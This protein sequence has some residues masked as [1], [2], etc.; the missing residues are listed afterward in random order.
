MFTNINRLVLEEKETFISLLDT[1]YKTNSKIFDSR[2]LDH[3]VYYLVTLEKWIEV[4]T[5]MKKK[6]SS[7]LKYLNI[8]VNEVLDLYGKCKDLMNIMTSSKIIIEDLE[9]DM[10]IKE[11]LPALLDLYIKFTLSL[12]D[13]Q[14]KCL[15]RFSHNTKQTPRLYIPF[16]YTLNKLIRGCVVLQDE[17]NLNSGEVYVQKGHIKD[18]IY[19][20][21]EGVNFGNIEIIAYTYRKVLHNIRLQQGNNLIEVQAPYLPESWCYMK[22]REEQVQYTQRLKDVAFAYSNYCFVGYN[23]IQ[24]EEGKN[25][26]YINFPMEGVYN[27]S[28]LISIALV[29]QHELMLVY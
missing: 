1:I 24:N 22:G 20:Y 6:S 28:S 3:Q 4:L 14:V 23:T 26:F 27:K 21:R 18:N 17:Q 25:K 12:E 13:I 29:G 2:I 10:I 5:E 7:I 9:T 15:Q 19:R 8:D 16:S 11:Q